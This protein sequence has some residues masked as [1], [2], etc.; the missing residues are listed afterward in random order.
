MQ[1][2]KT[3]PADTN[4]AARKHLLVRAFFNP[5]H[6]FPGALPGHRPAVRNRP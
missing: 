2:L 4:C 3:Y 1:T 6:G 5:D